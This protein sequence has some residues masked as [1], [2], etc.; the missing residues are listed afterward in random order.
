[1]SEAVNG[2]AITPEVDATRPWLG[3]LPF[4]TATSA[5]FFGRDAEIDAILDRIE[6][7]TLTILY[8]QS[9]LGKTSLLGGGVFPK[10]QERNKS[11]VLLRLDHA[12]SAPSLLEQTREALQ[13]SLPD[14]TWP[15]DASDITLWE[16]VHRMPLLIPEGTP[17][18][19]LIFD[20]FEEIFTLGRQD[21]EREERVAAWLEQ[22][23]D[24]IQ[25]RPPK[26]LEE[27]FAENRRLARDYEF[28][29]TPIRFLFSL[30]E[31]YLSHLE[32][33]KSILPLL[34]QN[35]M[36]LHA[37]DGPQALEAVLGPASL[38]E[39]PLVSREVAI[40]IIRT[41]ARVPAET[42][43]TKIHA[44]PPLLSLLCEQLNS[45]RLA[46]GAERI[47]ASMVSERSEDILHHFYED[48]FEVFRDDYREMIREIIED[49]MVTFGGHRHPVAREDAEEELSARGVP[50]PKEVF[51]TLIRRRL[52][53][54]EEQ[55]GVPRLE[56]THDV[57]LP[58]LIRSRKERRERVEREKRQRLAAEEALKTRK[59]RL[60]TTAM[61]VL[62]LAALAGAAF[63]WHSSREAIS[64]RDEAR[65]NEGLGWLLRA[66]VAEERGKQY[67]GTLLYAA[68]AI[69]F[70]GAGRPAAGA[71][72]PLQLI[73]ARTYSEEYKS[74]KQWLDDRP[75]YRPVWSSAIRKP[76][77]AGLSLSPCGRYLVT[78][79][80]DGTIELWDLSTPDDPT[81]IVTG[82]ADIMDLVY[83]PEGDHFAIARKAGAG[84][85]EIPTKTFTGLGD[86]QVSALAYSPDGRTLAGSAANGDLLLW[87]D[88]KLTTVTTG[89]NQP[90][91]RIAFSADNSVVAMA[92]PGCGVSVFFPLAGHASLAWTEAGEVAPGKTGTNGGGHPPLD[93]T[94]VAVSS[95]G[96]RIA[97]GDEKGGIGIWEVASAIRLF[98]APIEQRH[99][100]A[101]RDLC[102]RQ[103]GTELAS[104]ANDTFIKLWDLKSG[105]PAIT[106]TLT[107]H[108]SPVT[109]VR[110]VP[111]GDLL[112]SAGED[113]SAKLWDVSGTRGTAPD[114]FRYYHEKWY[115]LGNKLEPSKSMAPI[116]SM[117]GDSL[118]QIAGTGSMIVPEWGGRTGF[119][120]LPDN[121][122]VGHWQK[123][124]QQEVFDRMLAD[125]DW[126]SAIETLREVPQDDRGPE[127]SKLAS[128][129]MKD[130]SEAATAGRWTLVDLRLRQLEHTGEKLPAEAKDLQDQRH[131]LAREETNFTNGEKMELVWCKAG[132]ALL[133][134]PANEPG[135][136][137][138]NDNGLI[139]DDGERQYHATLT[140]GFWISSCEV[141]IQQW[142]AL[143][144]LNSVRLET[145][146]E[147]C[148]VHNV[149]W[150]DAM[151][152]C[153]KLTD[154]ERS[155][156]LVP[157]GWEY[158][159]PTKAQWEYACRAGTRTA[160]YFGEDS[161][162]LY[163]YANFKD[164]SSGVKGA[165]PV[166]NDGFPKLAPV[167]SFPPNA[168]NIH[169]MH[170]NVA[171]WCR[172]SHDTMNKSPER[173][174][175]QTDPWVR[176][177]KDRVIRGGSYRDPALE[178][179][180][181]F[182][183]ASV[184]TSTSPSNGLRP[185][186]TKIRK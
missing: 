184:P 90:A 63:G 138:T 54:A 119:I 58:L 154:L 61:S 94:A 110:Y 174:D 135:H 23:A 29:R 84:L 70:E 10:L 122:I 108:V 3:L 78:G 65:F 160:Y 5:F 36:P 107:G 83:H 153:S 105:E 130:A 48:S 139:E 21:P 131:R 146:Q 7:N 117:K 57:L 86:V 173:A 31:D 134:S 143:M 168:W 176:E 118:G 67:P 6:E 96:L 98:E 49:R 99:R 166:Q 100:G 106:A 152:Y 52:L 147:D 37:L 93:A 140:Q 129:I 40:S 8:G 125:R 169:N 2:S 41:V 103:D 60:L 50:Q 104:S 77:I 101:V 85:W 164:K 183:R 159:L 124:Q 150:E 179:R 28:G 116:D 16:L 1:M 42:P 71:D 115:K 69:G 30:R 17:A 181:S 102:F 133:G 113:G 25:S 141:T 175:H 97:I 26:T 44:V 14:A 156:G 80:I 62:T 20:Q 15:A 91:S 88:G 177:G 162:Q 43:L 92:T 172:D 82:S 64:Q 39:P 72:L 155:R 12:P 38:S 59:R 165:N 73:P 9:G 27:R 163:K 142:T 114:L 46:A 148:P 68:K 127:I 22:I 11:P 144:G 76:A 121:S 171:E 13:R 35:R 149:S 19:V 120:S 111:G 4:S 182:G 55:G 128:G 66:E 18:P 185:V 180:S 24:L 81:Q 137:D 56:I 126:T 136:D 53:T 33:W 151:K 75:A 47:D 109:K 89:H 112:A 167:K 178:C 79:A 170:G 161:S 34:A 74:A 186:L 157:A 32:E 132:T 95:D 145:T 87:N 158:M 45:A 51:D 123:G